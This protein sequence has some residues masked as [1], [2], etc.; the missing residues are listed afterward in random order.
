MLKKSW[1]FLI[2]PNSV[3]LKLLFDFSQMHPFKADIHPYLLPTISIS[4][5]RAGLGIEE[6][7]QQ[8]GLQQ[9]VLRPLMEEVR[10]DARDKMTL[11][12]LHEIER[13]STTRLPDQ[14]YWPRLRSHY[15]RVTEGSLHTRS[16]FLWVETQYW[17]VS[18]RLD[19]YSWAA[20]V[21][22]SDFASI[23]VQSPLLHS[24]KTLGF[25]R[26]FK[27]TLSS[28][29]LVRVLQSTIW[30]CMA[31]NWRCWFRG[32]KRGRPDPST[33]KPKEMKKV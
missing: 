33:G 23:R 19:H 7:L 2:P 20:K 16:R 29:G 32:W 1:N 6:W 21:S 4:A 30:T 24:S 26:T 14:S 15:W 12:T 18:W 31:C 27:T 11:Y 28:P 17:V 10:K 5:I 25:H 13:Q 3:R 8:G 22:S 9:T